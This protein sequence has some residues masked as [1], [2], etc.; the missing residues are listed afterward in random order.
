MSKRLEEEYRK[1]VE[2]EVPDLWSRI[3]SG[4]REKNIE[5]TV[6]ENSVNSAA[7]NPVNNA[8][9]YPANNSVNYA[10]NTATNPS[11]KPKKKKPV[12]IRLIPWM[13]GI[14]V[15]AIIAIFVLPAVLRTSNRSK[16]AAIQ[17]NAMIGY[18]AA[19]NEI[20]APVEGA[21]AEPAGDMQ[22]A[23]EEYE[24]GERSFAPTTKQNTKGDTETDGAEPEAVAEAEED[25]A[26][27]YVYITD[28]DTS[29]NGQICSLFRSEDYYDFSELLNDGSAGNE[30]W[31]ISD[32]SQVDAEEGSCYSAYVD[33]NK[34]V[35]I[36][37]IDLE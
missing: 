13:G 27:F 14:A 15:A 24:K 25:T 11:V 19:V 37:K 16:K 28:V 32:A 9:N 4:L 20:A 6:T 34:I 33:G 17:E 26:E 2:S 29:G 8:V 35:L 23:P 7:N 10:A 18:D 3:E 12:I 1:M 31:E 21:A 30:E 22:E 36:E 5:S